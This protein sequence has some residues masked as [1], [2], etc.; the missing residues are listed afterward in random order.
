MDAMLALDCETLLEPLSG[1]SPAG[2]E[3]HF[4]LTL[5]PA[6]R[7]L[8]RE[9]SADAFDDATRPA[10]LKRADWPEA[11]RQCQDALTTKAK[12]LR[13]ACHL[14]EAR[15]RL[16]GIAG[17]D[18]GLELVTRLVEDCWDR[19][20]PAIG[21]DAIE[22]RATPLANMLDDPDRGV[23]FPS[24]LRTLP[25]IG[26]E[27]TSYSYGEWVRLRAGRKPEDTEQL[28]SVRRQTPPERFKQLFEEAASAAAWADRLSAALENQ[29]GDRAP[30]LLSLRT[31]IGDLKGLLADELARLGYPTDGSGDAT[32][33]PSTNDTALSISPLGGE[34]REQLYARLD[35]TAE[36]LRAMEPHSPIPYLIKRAVRLGRLPFPSLIQQVIREPLVLSEIHREFGIAE[37]DEAEV[38]A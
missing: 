1:D 36:R 20:T 10:N 37:P 33:E 27:A 13:T 16:D 25:L 32:E 30:G 4:A 14:V 17:L 12:D 19:V 7:E 6:L 11:A 29:L 8:R 22:T 26:T 24:L 38:L 28:A 18:A 23:C 34:Q 15:T 5:A 3:S 35:E 9:E 21:D 31:A 2:D